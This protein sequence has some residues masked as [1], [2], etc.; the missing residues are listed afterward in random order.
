MFTTECNVFNTCFGL[1]KY[2]DYCERI[3]CLCEVYSCKK[4]FSDE[5]KC[6]LTSKNDCNISKE[7]WCNVPETDKNIEKTNAFVFMRHQ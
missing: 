7:V 4:F 6:I 5:A 2:K 3:R 1:K